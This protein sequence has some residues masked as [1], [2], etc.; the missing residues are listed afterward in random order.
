LVGTPTGIE[1]V[2]QPGKGRVLTARR[3]GHARRR[4]AHLVGGGGGV[5]PR[6]DRAL[7]GPGGVLEMELGLRA[8]A[9]VV[10]LRPA[11]EPQ[12]ASLSAVQQRLAEVALRHAERDRLERGTVMPTGDQAQVVAADHVGLDQ[13]YRPDCHA[14]TGPADSEWPGAVERRDEL[15]REAAR[16]EGEVE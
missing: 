5:K 16:R 6:P 1:P 15:R 7:I 12:P 8:A 14:R 2:L 9:P 10:D 3:R 11:R 4:A 13:V